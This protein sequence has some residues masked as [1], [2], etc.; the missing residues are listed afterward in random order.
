MRK[1]LVII[2][3]GIILSGC[4][5][6]TSSD[7]ESTPPVVI[8]TA[9]VQLTDTVGYPDKIKVSAKLP[10]EQALSAANDYHPISGKWFG[11]ENEFNL[12]TSYTSDETR[13]GNEVGAALGQ[14]PEGRSVRFQIT[15]RDI[16]G[17]RLQLITEYVADI[18]NTV[19]G[20]LDFSYK[21]PEQP[22]TNY[23]LSIEIVSPKGVIE[24]TLITPIFVPPNELNARLTVKQ[25]TKNTERTEL[26]IYNAGPTDLNLGYGYSIYRK[27]SAGWKM[28]PNELA[29]PA[30]AIHVKPGE[31][32]KEQVLFPQNLQPGQYRLVKN[33]EG[34]NTDLTVNLAADINVY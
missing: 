7:F 30:I 17:K 9:I 19:D 22:N 33:I 24:D 16:D 31:S 3:F 32:F 15:S 5:S 10:R 26:S 11:G 1:I 28:T 18:K 27:E 4:Q 23:L 13:A 25:P 2:T 34:N 20:R 8:D 12:I 14:V 29:V 6:K 21:I